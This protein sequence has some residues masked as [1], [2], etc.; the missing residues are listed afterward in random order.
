MDIK[1]YRAL[2]L[3]ITLGFALLAASPLIV[4]VIP[5]KETA[6]FS[7]IWILG[8]NHIAS[9]Y[10][11]IIRN[12]ETNS[13]FIGGRNNMGEPSYYMVYVKLLNSTFSVREEN[14][15]INSYLDPM[16]EFKFFVDNN[17]VWEIP[18]TFKFEDISAVD[19]VLSVQNFD[20]NGINFPIEASSTFNLEKAG[21]F[22]DLTFE[23]WR[24]NVQTNNF[25][26]DGR[27]VSLHLKME[28]S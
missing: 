17:D 11:S 24:Y 7:E 26:Y 28:I 3:A 12:G 2:F 10:P 15:F 23:L 8:S 25:A 5:K 9:G 19:N 18:V 6:F 21:F 22:F 1:S 4:E 20:I 27:F 16:Y 13:I 14:V